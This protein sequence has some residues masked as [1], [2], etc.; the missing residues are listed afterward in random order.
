MTRKVRY[1]PILPSLGRGEVGDRWG[2]VG[3]IPA[4]QTPL[5]CV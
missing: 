2:E 5:F 1:V 4:I 3:G